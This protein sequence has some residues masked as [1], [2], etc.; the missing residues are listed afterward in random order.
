MTVAIGLVC[1]DGVIVASDSM[2]STSTGNAMPSQKVNAFQHNP[3]IWTAAGSVYV[4]EEVAVEFAAKLDSKPELVFTEPKIDLLRNK[5]KGVLQ[6]TVLKCYKSALSTSPFA[7]G[8]TSASMISAFLLLG[9]SDGTGW[10]LE[11][12]HDGSLNWH[13][14]RGFYAIGSGGPFAQV[15]HALM[16]HY[17]VED[18][19]LEQ[20]LRLAYR[21]IETTCSASSGYVGLPVQLAVA[22]AAGARVLTS[23]E[24]ND[25]GTAVERWM[26][27][28][29]DTLQ[30]SPGTPEPVDALP[31]VDNA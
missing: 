27:L 22:D 16:K 25:V 18:L 5:V 2:A 28:E 26:E 23:D 20:G 13:H 29:R 1:K 30:M 6:P 12:D 9:Y 17:M 21:A 15:C 11:M 4:K 10:F 14:D 8:Q 3:V 7:P 31:S 24:V 19:S